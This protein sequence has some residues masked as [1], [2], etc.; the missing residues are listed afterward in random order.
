[1]IFRRREEEEEQKRIPIVRAIR[2]EE[3]NKTKKSNR[4]EPILT[5]QHIK[6]YIL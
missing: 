3:K 2:R 1:L 4:P 6:F 5:I